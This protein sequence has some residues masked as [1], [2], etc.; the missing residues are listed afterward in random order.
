MAYYGIQTALLDIKLVPENMEVSGWRAPGDP[1]VSP[2]YCHCHELLKTREI[3][4]V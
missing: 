4:R 2:A 3:A 1:N